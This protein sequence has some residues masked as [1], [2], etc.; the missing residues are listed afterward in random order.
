MTTTRSQRAQSHNSG[1]RGIKETRM[2]RGAGPPRLF[3]RV[4]FPFTLQEA[5]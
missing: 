2:G 3:S 1:V 5:D 4:Q